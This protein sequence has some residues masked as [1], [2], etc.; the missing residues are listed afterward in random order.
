MKV[1]VIADIHANLPALEAV[2]KRISELECNQVFSIG[3]AVAI[4]PFPQETLDVL[5]ANQVELLMGNHE[6]ALLQLIPSDQRNVV[7]PGEAVHERWVRQQVQE[8]HITRLKHIP[9]ERILSTLGITVR[10]LHYAYDEQ[11]ILREMTPLNA[12]SLGVLFGSDDDLVCFG[13]TH[14]ELDVV[15]RTR[16]V[17]P[18]AAGCSTDGTARFA[19]VEIE[20]GSLRVT[21]HKVRY[22]VEKTL[23]AMDDRKVPDR[24]FIKKVFFGV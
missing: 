9:Y 23:R 7:S 20:E 10:L 8:G 4:G 19:T 17:N 22:S 24:H 1:A 11:G 12:Q 3:D 13:H 6:E 14:K 2:L 16:Y 15:S 5:W 18:G 21:S